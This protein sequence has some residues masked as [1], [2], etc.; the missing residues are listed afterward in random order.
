MVRGNGKSESIKKQ[1]K[2]DLIDK[3]KDKLKAT[4]EKDEDREREREHERSDVRFRKWIDKGIGI[5]Q[6]KMDM[7]KKSYQISNKIVQSE[8][9]AATVKLQDLIKKFEGASLDWF[10]FRNQFVTE[11][12]KVDKPRKFSSENFIRLTIYY[13]VK[14][15]VLFQNL[16]QS[17]FW[18]KIEN[19]NGIVYC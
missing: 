19:L 5:E 15:S 7:K 10:R 6:I 3:L 14:F 9:R 11:I 4:T 18:D 17:Y 13:F 12:N 16:F 1:S 8:E 2:G